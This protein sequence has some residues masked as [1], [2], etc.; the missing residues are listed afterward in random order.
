[1]SPAPACIA[2]SRTASPQLV[3]PSSFAAPSSSAMA[4]GARA[5]AIR[6]GL[7]VHRLLQFLPEVP[8]E[9]R[10]E[11]ARRHLARH[12][13]DVA[14]QERDELLSS[15]FALLDDPRFAALFGPGTR[16]EVPIVGRLARNGRPA[17]RVSGQVDR[18]AVT[19]EFVL[20]ADYKSDRPAPRQISEVPPAY[21][22]Q[23]ALYRAV[24][25]RIFPERPVRAGLLW[26][27][28]PDLMDLPQVV[29]D[30]AA[31]DAL[32]NGS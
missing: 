30:N 11:A 8:P 14:E 15:V 27:E 9:R 23:L 16:A 29:L 3:V 24:L 7:I 12:L 1:L 2:P 6:R 4:V 31:R 22:L 5:G 13:A 19:D 28:V 32:A 26:I 25:A 10:D 20:I 21:I 17:L 18:L